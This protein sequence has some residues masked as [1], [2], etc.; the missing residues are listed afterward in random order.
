ML[1]SR[2]KSLLL[3]LAAG[4]AFALTAS[5]QQ[6]DVANPAAT[7]QHKALAALVGEFDQESLIK[8]G[9]GEPVKARSTSRGRWILGGRFVEVDGV[10]NPGEKLQGERKLIYGYDPAAKLYTLYNIDTSDPVAT[11]AKGTYDDRTKI[12]SFD[13]ERSMGSAKM[14]FRW[15]LRVLEGGVIEQKIQVKA[16][17]G[18]LVEA[19]TVVHTPKR[20]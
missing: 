3:A 1:S 2:P 11:T 4:A 18:K 16:N 8:M 14:P 12:F 6:T 5:A 20:R 15:T 7:D 13:G 19:V 17:E 10:S 9:P